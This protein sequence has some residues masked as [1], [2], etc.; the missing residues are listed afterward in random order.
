MD[1]TFLPLL[2]VSDTNTGLALAAAAAAAAAAAIVAADWWLL[3]LLAAGGWAR[4]AREVE[5]DLAV[6]DRDPPP[7]LLLS[8]EDLEAAPAA[9]CGRVALV[10]AATS[11]ACAL[12]SWERTPLAAL[13]ALTDLAMAGTTGDDLVSCE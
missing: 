11:A 12:A 8:R 7:P 2:L 9:D 1:D 5:A 3:L 4:D 10:A 13:L 6:A